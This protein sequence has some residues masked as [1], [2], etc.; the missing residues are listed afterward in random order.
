MTIIRNDSAYGRANHGCCLRRKGKHVEDKKREQGVTCALCERRNDDIACG[1][2]MLPPAA[3]IER[4]GTVEAPCHKRRDG[5][6]EES[7]GK[8]MVG[9]VGNGCEDGQVDG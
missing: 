8:R 3:G 7:D 6:C 5:N 9:M 2:G 1:F 4:Q